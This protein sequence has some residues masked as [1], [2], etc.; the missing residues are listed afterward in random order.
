MNIETIPG[1][2]AITPV[3]AYRIRPL[4]WRNCAW[5]VALSARSTIN[6][7]KSLTTEA[8][9][10]N[11]VKEKANRTP[12]L[13]EPNPDILYTIDAVERLVQMSQRTIFIYCKHGL[14]AAVTDPEFGGYY[15]N[16]EAIRM[17]RR[18]G[19]LQVT[20]GVNLAGIKFIL[21]LTDEVQRLRKVLA[22]STPDLI[23]KIRGNE[24]ICQSRKNSPL[25]MIQQ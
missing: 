11:R 19:H 22:M 16:R 18:I 3:N 23:N 7:D 4:I 9:P 24:T 21:D 2:R 25:R 6:T 15:F 8:K 17:L 20:H 14:I 1:A 12:Q 13:F 10:M 5:N